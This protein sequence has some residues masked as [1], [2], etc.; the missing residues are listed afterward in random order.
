MAVS[1]KETIRPKSEY[2]GD[3]LVG[4]TIRFDPKNLVGVNGDH[5]ITGMIIALHGGSNHI[6]VSYGS[7]VAT[8]S[9]SRI[10]AGGSN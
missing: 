4:S 9:P 2:T 8:I 5:C 10:V 7:R 3:Y 1:R 6:D